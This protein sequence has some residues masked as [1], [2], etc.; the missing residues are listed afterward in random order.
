MGEGEQ[1]PG[2]LVERAAAEERRHLGRREAGGDGEEGH[3][4]DQL[5]QRK[6]AAGGAAGFSGQ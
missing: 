3:D 5:D 6:G 4:Q 2:F 1:A